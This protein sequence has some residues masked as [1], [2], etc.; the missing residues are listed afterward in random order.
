MHMNVRN[1]TLKIFM[2]FPI[3]TLLSF[4]PLMT[5]LLSVIGLAGMLYTLFR[6]GVVRK[7]I[8]LVTTT[9]LLVVWSYINTLEPII[10]INETIYFI[11]LI[12]FTVFLVNI[13]NHVI[14]FMKRNTKYLKNI[15]FIW[16]ALVVFS[17]IFP[18]SYD[19]GVFVSFAESTFRLSP[20]AIFIMALSSVLIA[21]EKKKQYICYSIIPWLAIL[22]GAS[23]TYLVLGIAMLMLNLSMI[24]KNKKTY[25]L[26]VV[27]MLLIGGLIV[28]NTSMGDKFTSSI[29]EQEY[30]DE[31]GVFSSGRSNF[32]VKDLDAFNKQNF[33]NRMFG[34][35]FN[36]I[37]IVNGAIPGTDKDG[38]WAHN[39]FIQIVIT[40]G[41]VGLLVYLINMRTMFSRILTKR[42]PILIAF[43]LVLIWFFNAMFNMYYTYICS[44]IALPI[45]MFSCEIYKQENDKWFG[46]KE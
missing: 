25:L 36:F 30:L 23:R 10:N 24:Y 7:G 28:V 31:L 41:Y 1:F 37:R 5:T 8:L 18:F 32:W 9:C 2:F 39:D 26:I 34:C 42:I 6:Y 16:C 22:F 4:I 38:I 33:K 12:I 17:V 44:M 15:C 40:H 20:S 35:G 21:T 45:V 3:F 29:T 43:L 46:E 27:I 11:Y 13:K 19:M 14:D